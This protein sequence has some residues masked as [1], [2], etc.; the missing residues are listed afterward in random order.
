MAKLI[1]Y[2]KTK[3]R[4]TLKSGNDIRR[5]LEHKSNTKKIFT[6]KRNTKR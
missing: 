4:K 2:L 3:D 6:S 5:T 1:R